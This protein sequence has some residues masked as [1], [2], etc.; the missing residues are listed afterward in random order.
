M[1]QGGGA[2]GTHAARAAAQPQPR[3]VE[4]HACAHAVEGI[5]LLFPHHVHPLPRIGVQQ[6]RPAE[7]R[8]CGRVMVGS[9]RRRLSGAHRS[10]GSGGSGGAEAGLA[11]A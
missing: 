1:R 5:V 4:P 7:T 11:R 8:T 9:L 3:H 10:G 2:R 6:Q